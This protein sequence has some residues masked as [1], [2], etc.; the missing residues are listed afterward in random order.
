MTQVTVNL[1]IP[2]ELYQQLEKLAN[3]DQTDPITLLSDLV[4]LAEQRQAWLR[5][6]EALQQQ[7]QAEGGLAIPDTEEEAIE[8]LRQ[9]RYAIFKAEYAHL[10]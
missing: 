1:P 3:Q 2:V 10:Y 7:I 6:F 8:Q 5:E 9:T 4:D